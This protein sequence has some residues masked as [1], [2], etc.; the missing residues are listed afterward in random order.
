MAT[1]DGFTR[2][3]LA[4]RRPNTLAADFCRAALKEAI[5][6]FGPPEIMNTDQGSPFPSFAWTDRRK[7]P[8]TRIARHGQRRRCDN[9]V[10]ERPWRSL[11]DACAPCMPDPK[12][13]PLKWLTSRRKARRTSAWKSPCLR[14][15]GSQAKP[16]IGHKMTFTNHNRPHTCLGGTPPAGFYRSAIA[17]TQADQQA[18]KVA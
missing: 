6:K 5:H 12:T 14:E 3:G 16:A 18:Q 13:I 11:K 15:P 4:R 8:G 10:I 7:R 2:K 1:L 9:L 17:K